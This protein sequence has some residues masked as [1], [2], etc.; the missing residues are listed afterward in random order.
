MVDLQEKFDAASPQRLLSPNSLSNNPS[1]QTSLVRSSHDNLSSRECEIVKKGIERLEKQILKF[2]NVF[3]PGDQ[4]NI[5]LLKKCKT[6]DVPAV[7]SGMVN[8]QKAL[9]KYVGFS[10]MDPEYCDG[11]GELME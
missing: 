4:T 11:I 7:N 1:P 8:I 9:Q 5:A 6:V 2:I 3:I 10:G